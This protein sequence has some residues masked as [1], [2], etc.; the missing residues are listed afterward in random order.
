MCER[1]YERIDVTKATASKPQ[2]IVDQLEKVA[3]TEGGICAVNTLARGATA[4]AINCM[5]DRAVLRAGLGDFLEIT[6][7]TGSADPRRSHLMAAAA[8]GFM[9]V[10]EWLLSDEV[11]A[12]ADNPGP[13]TT[14]HEDQRQ[15]Q[16]RQ[17]LVTD[18]VL[19]DK[20][21]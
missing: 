1:L 21:S 3:T 6:Q 8:G 7:S 4:G 2:D 12:S 18:L 15:I 5:N 10:L 19:T 11:H 14:Y 20:L 13:Y 17:T 9:P 16:D